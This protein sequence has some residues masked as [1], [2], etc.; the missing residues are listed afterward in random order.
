MR[1][2]SE[3]PRVAF[4]SVD[5][6]TRAIRLAAKVGGETEL[7]RIP[8]N[9]YAPDHSIWWLAPSSEDPAYRYGKIVIDE[10]PRA[11]PGSMIIGLEVEKGVGE[12]V[13][14]AYRTSVR[15]GRYVMDRTW[16][17]PRRLLPALQSHNFADEARRAEQVAKLPLTLAIDADFVDPPQP[18]DDPSSGRPPAVDRARFEVSQGRLELIDI[19]DSSE[20][21]LAGIETARTFADVAR[22]LERIPQADWVWVSLVIGVR[23]DAGTG[24]DVWSGTKIWRD[25]CAP[26]SA[27]LI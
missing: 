4:D 25:V 17:W 22:A 3:L 13:A 7:F 16:L 20:R 2:V 5:D 27:W 8:F 11:G 23:F 9:R 18:H 6:A 21:R 24:K 15:G 12:P 14:D 26:W 19:H 1:D 10:G